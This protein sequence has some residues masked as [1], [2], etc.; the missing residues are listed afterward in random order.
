MNRPKRVLTKSAEA[1]SGR[2][3][4]MKRI[5]ARPAIPRYTERA[6]YFPSWS[7]EATFQFLMQRDRARILGT[8]LRLSLAPRVNFRPQSMRSR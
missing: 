6:T 3:Q 5:R 2:Q 7:S 1:S 4:S 8:C